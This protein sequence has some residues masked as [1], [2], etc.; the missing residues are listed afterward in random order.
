MTTRITVSGDPAVQTLE[1]EKDGVK[2]ALTPDEAIKLARDLVR[3][4]P[5]RVKASLAAHLS[6]IVAKTLS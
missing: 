5:L 2:L 4:L 1:I 6:G 3:V